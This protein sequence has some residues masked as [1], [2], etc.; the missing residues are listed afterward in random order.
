MVWNKTLW[1]V[2]V[3]YSFGSKVLL[4]VWHLPEYFIIFI[5]ESI[6]HIIKK[7]K[8]NILE[9]LSNESLFFKLAVKSTSSWAVRNR[10]Q[11]VTRMTVDMVET[12]FSH[13]GENTFNSFINL[14][15]DIYFLCNYSFNTLNIT[16]YFSYT[17]KS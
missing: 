2:Q 5:N 14:L 8:E 9:I 11:Y 1:D 13:F 12:F 6:I 4:T 16:C 10:K 7:K 3:I 17:F 15:S